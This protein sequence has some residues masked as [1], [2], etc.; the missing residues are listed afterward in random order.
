MRLVLFDIHGTLLPARGAG[1]RAPGRALERLYGT[2]GAIDGY[3]VC[4]F[5]SFADAGDAADERL[6]EEARPQRD[7]HHVQAGG[8]D[9]LREE[10]RPHRGLLHVQA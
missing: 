10:A 1:R 7:F 6:R 4:C 5:D 2:R 9:R 3:D 8:R